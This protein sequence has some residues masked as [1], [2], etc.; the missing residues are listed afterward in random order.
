M[1]RAARRARNG[2]SAGLRGL[3]PL[4]HSSWIDDITGLLALLPVHALT[5]L[6]LS[7]EETVVELALAE[8]NR[9]PKKGGGSNCSG[10]WPWNVHE[11]GEPHV[12]RRMDRLCRR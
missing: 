9:R 4:V 3:P 7:D 5:T 1:P 8:L 10:A 6:L 2:R 12:W 11:R